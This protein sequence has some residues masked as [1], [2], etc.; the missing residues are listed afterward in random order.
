MKPAVQDNPSEVKPVASFDD[1]TNFYLHPGQWFASSARYAVTTILGSCVSICLWDPRS[2]IGGLNHFL[3][4][5]FGGEG[6]AS[7]RFG[8]VAF[9]ELLEKLLALG[10]RKQDL[11]SKIFGG[12][13]VLEAFRSKENHLGQK[14]VRVAERLL[15]AEGIPL[16]HRNVGGLRGRKLIFHTDSGAVWV[17][18]L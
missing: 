7:S 3:L 10:C 1:R 5:T 13:C 2:K 15:D 11:Q 18:Q 17:K 8:N 6:L 4:P 9:Y 16:I 14:N 12:A